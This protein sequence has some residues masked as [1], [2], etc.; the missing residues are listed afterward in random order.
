MNRN[1]SPTSDGL[2]GSPSAHTN[3]T[4]I[5]KEKKKKR[6]TAIQSFLSLPQ[7]CTLFLSL[8]VCVLSFTLSHFKP[9]TH[10]SRHLLPAPD[11]QQHLIFQVWMQLPFPPFFRCPTFFLKGVPPEPNGQYTLFSAR[12]IT[13]TKIFSLF[14]FSFVPPNTRGPIIS[15]TNKFL[16]LP[17]PSP[18]FSLWHPIRRISRLRRHS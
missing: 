2:V 9:P 18:P 4:Q 5:R 14:L 6:K 15:T 16:Q 13:W 1:T 17:A 11:V 3:P 8:R 12:L 10:P 7:T